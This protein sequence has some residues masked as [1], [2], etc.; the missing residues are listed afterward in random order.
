M[1]SMTGA[2]GDSESDVTSD[3]TFS[4]GNLFRLAYP[5]FVWS[6]FGGMGGWVG[7]MLGESCGGG[8]GGCVQYWCWVFRYILL[9][10]YLSNVGFAGFLFVFFI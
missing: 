1:V 2:T 4:F 6:I 10:E 8:G 9:I 7:Y 3:Y 5:V